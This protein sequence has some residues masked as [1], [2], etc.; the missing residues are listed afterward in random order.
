MSDERLTDHP[1]IAEVVSE[2]RRIEETLRDVALDSLREA[3]QRGEEKVSKRQRRLEQ[4]RRAVAKAI[5]VLDPTEV[6]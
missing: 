3:A 1:S 2:L 6:F 5:N 4:A